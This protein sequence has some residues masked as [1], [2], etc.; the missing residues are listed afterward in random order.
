MKAWDDAANKAATWTGSAPA[1]AAACALVVVW[2]ATGPVMG[3]SDTHQLLI[4]TTTTVITFLLVFLIQRSQDSDTHEV[5]ARLDRIDET[6]A[7][8]EARLP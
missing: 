2:A 8:I 5:L 4:N 3:W 7:R 1:F 6:L